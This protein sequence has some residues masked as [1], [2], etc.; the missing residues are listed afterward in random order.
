MSNLKTPLGITSFPVKSR[1]IRR[2]LVRRYDR[3]PECGHNL[4]T[5]GECNTCDYDAIREFPKVERE[6]F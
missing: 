2:E 6:G 1:P 3:C 4:D 5:G